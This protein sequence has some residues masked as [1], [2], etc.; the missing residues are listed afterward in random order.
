[1]N[2]AAT[3]GGA[4]S[5]RPFLDAGLAHAVAVK[6]LDER[7][8]ACANIR[9]SITSLYVW[10]GTQNQTEETGVLFKT[11]TALLDRAV[12]RSAELYPCA[13]PSGCNS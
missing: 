10:P 11:V 2:A 3:G 6:A 9:G 8:V 7:R 12:Q 5:W 13:V 4:M 1:M